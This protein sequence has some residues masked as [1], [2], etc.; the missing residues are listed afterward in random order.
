MSDARV[1]SAD[2]NHSQR[3]TD[4][5]ATRKLDCLESLPLDRF[6]EPAKEDGRRGAWRV[7]LRGA[8]LQEE[9]LCSVS[10]SNTTQIFQLLIWLSEFCGQPAGV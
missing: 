4:P 6:Q 5:G 10:T 3:N 2:R 8:T 7:T 9:E 1:V